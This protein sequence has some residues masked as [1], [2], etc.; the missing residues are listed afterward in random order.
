[1]RSSW[2]LGVWSRDDSAAA[3]IGSHF[4]TSGSFTLSASQARAK[5]DSAAARKAKKEA[6]NAQRIKDFKSGSYELGGGVPDKQI[7]RA[8]V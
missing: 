8:H 5:E 1:M 2:F 7:G 6:M 3:T 4:C